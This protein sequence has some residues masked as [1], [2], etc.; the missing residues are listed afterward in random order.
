MLKLPSLV[1]AQTCVRWPA[2][3]VEAPSI[4]MHCPRAASTCPLHDLGP[5]CCLLTLMLL[6]GLH[7]CRCLS[8]SC[9]APA[10]RVPWGPG[11]DGSSISEPTLR[12][13]RVSGRCHVATGGSGCLQLISGR[14]IRSTVLQKQMI[15]FSFLFIYKNNFISLN[16]I[17]T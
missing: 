6:T 12:P 17:I 11:Q 2:W 5:Q 9:S 7:T 8:P 14:L 4:R 1:S 13:C 15:Q 16:H 10:S 3:P